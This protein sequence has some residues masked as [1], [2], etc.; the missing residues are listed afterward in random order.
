MT[1]ARSYRAHTRRSRLLLILLAALAAAV[2]VPLHAQGSL[3]QSSGAILIDG[4]VQTATGQPAESA[5]V[6][7]EEQGRSSVETKT[8]ADGSFRLSAK[9]AGTYVLRAEKPGWRAAVTPAIFLSAGE[10]K[11]I[12]LV[13]E[14]QEMDQRLT[15]SSTS[16]SGEMELHD[17]PNFV[18]AGVID[19]T[20]FGGH[21]SETSRRTSEALTSQ[22]VGLKADSPHVLSTDVPRRES[23]HPAS[24]ASESELRQVLAKT[25]GSFQ[26]NHELGNFLLRAGRYP[27]AVSLLESAY[28]IRPDDYTN[29]YDLARAYQAAGDFMAARQQAQR[30]LAAAP[31][32]E[33]HHLLGDIDERFGDPL[34][35]VREYEEATRGQA[36]ER[37]YYDWATELLLHRA[38]GPAA[39]WV[40]GLGYM[41]STQQREE[42]GRTVAQCGACG[43]M[44]S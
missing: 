26:A 39:A 33:L 42:H 19:G 9:H 4:R 8:T 32:A 11:H 27:E 23:M 43:T 22:T 38:P 15:S 14:S 41:G 2:R 24:C 44:R 36:S 37:N 17:E 29:A 18:V 10:E 20:S 28:H 7:L 1:S 21:G 31:N 40:G 30:I 16:S 6:V 34:G 5:V 35:A 25:H 12:G 3:A 13:L